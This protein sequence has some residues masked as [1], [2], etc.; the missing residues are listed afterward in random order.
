MGSGM[1][2]EMSKEGVV[3]KR[4]MRVDVPVVPLVEVVDVLRIVADYDWE[5][6]TT[7]LSRPQMTTEALLW[8]VKGGSIVLCLNQRLFRHVLFSLVLLKLLLLLL[9][10]LVV[11]VKVLVLLVSVLL[12]TL[13]ELLLE[14]LSLEF[15]LLLEKFD[16]LV[17]DL[18]RKWCRLRRMRLLNDVVGVVVVRKGEF[19][20]DDGLV[21]TVELLKVLDMLSLDLQLVV[22]LADELVV[23][24]RLRSVRIDIGR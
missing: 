10:L 20:R 4:R 22:L 23:Q 15:E 11:V 16:V 13:V 6:S 21:E 8:N 24:K 1:V 14:L 2:S 9:L 12:A 5:R 17:L 19:V 7:L 18:F 3:L